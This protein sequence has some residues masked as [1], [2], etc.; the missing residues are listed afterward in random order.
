[1]CGITGVWYSKQSE[2][3][4]ENLKLMTDAIVHRGPDAEGHWIDKNQRVGLG[5]RRLSIID[6]SVNGHQPMFLEDRYVITFNGEIY[7]YIELREELIQKEYTFKTSSDTE[8]LIVAYHEW[9][10]KCLTKLDGMFAFAIYDQSKDQLF[11]ARDRFGEKPFYFSFHNGNLYFG[12]EMKALWATGVPKS[13]NMSMLYNYLVNDLVENPNDQKETFYNG[14]QKLKSAN[15]FLYTGGKEIQ[16][17]NYW[18]LN[19]NVSVDLNLSDA[20]FRLQELLETSVQRRLR[21]DVPV[22]TSLSGGLDSSAIVSLVSEFSKHNHTFS[23]RF[24]GFSKDE[25]YFIEMVRE[26]FKTDH[27]NIVIDEN[28]LIPELDRLIY[29]QEEPFQTGSI[30]AQYCVYRE[31]RKNNVI[32]MLDGQGADEMLGG[33][34]KDFKFYLRELVQNGN[35]PA[36]FVQHILNNHNYNL[37]VDSK[38]K[39][40]IKAPGLYKTLAIVKNKLLKEVPSGINTEFNKA[41]SPKLSPFHEFNDLKS[42]LRYEMT[43]QGLEKLL[44]FAD[45]NSMAH[46]MEIRLP[47]LSHELVEFVFSLKSNLFLFEGW[48]KAILRNSMKDKLPHK[49]TYRKDKIGFE[50]PHEMWSNSESMNSLFIEANE[51]LLNE[52]IITQDYSNRWKI[53]MASKFITN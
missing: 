17:I 12:S 34:N 19:T 47:F 22:G 21:S 33:Y 48:S 36:K 37:T 20:S 1:M 9:G 49:I 35:N 28:E 6:L 51:T 24:P 38:E 31:A 45:R 10:E 41:F 15:Y 52:K 14:I 11:C 4:R 3:I 8:V 32:V 13:P 26:K 43:N 2:N 18:K 27:H 44:K 5:H 50:S 23:A 16:Q 39:L 42:M 40:R 7:N 46:S 25:G 30:F 53:I 29:H